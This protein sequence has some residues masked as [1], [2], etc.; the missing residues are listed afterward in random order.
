MQKHFTY[1]YNIIPTVSHHNFNSYLKNIFYN[2]YVD[3]GDMCN[4][5]YKAVRNQLMCVD[6]TEGVVANPIEDA[7]KKRSVEDGLLI[8]R[9]LYKARKKRDVEEENTTEESRLR[10][11]YRTTSGK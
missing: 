4:V 7:R 6:D 11:I 1:S 5:V 3:V 2:Q 9:L 10:G 8:T